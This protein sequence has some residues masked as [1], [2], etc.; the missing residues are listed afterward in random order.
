MADE[1]W[2]KVK[3]N[4]ESYSMTL[5]PYFAHQMKSSPR[6][7]LFTYSRYK[8]ALSMLPLKGGGRVL[9][10]GCNEGIG[11]IL[12]G[13]RAH[14]IMAVD[15]DEDAVAH[16]REHI[17]DPKLTFVCED[18]LGKAFGRFDAVVSLDVIEHIPK[19]QEGDFFHTITSNLDESGICIIGTPNATAARYASRESRIGH[20]NLYT[21]ERLD[22]AMRHRFKNVFMFGMNDEVVHTGFFPMC[23]YL[24]ALGSCKR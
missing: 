4:I 8:F 20:V 5:G 10:L 2:K 13:E 22:E 12:L 6:H 3:S 24:F 14:G 19:E 9:E 11:T 21:A 15:F 17:E 18:F 7:L 16:A 1:T 23:H